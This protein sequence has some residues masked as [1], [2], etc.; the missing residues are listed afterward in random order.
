MIFFE[1]F[2]TKQMMDEKNK[3][4]ALGLLLSLFLGLLYFGAF[5][6]STS[7]AIMLTCFLALIVAYILLKKDTTSSLQRHERM[8]AIALFLF[9]GS[10]LCSFIIGEGYKLESIRNPGMPSFLDLDLASKYLIGAIFFVLFFKI[11]FSIRKKIVFYAIVL[12]GV[13]SGL[14]AIYQRYVLGWSRVSGMSGIAEFADESSILCILSMV[15]F[16][17]LSA[18]KEKSLFAFSI[19]LSSFAVFLTGT[20]G[21]TLG[22]F[23]STLAFVCLIW[24]YKRSFLKL[25]IISSVFVF[26]SFTSVALFSGGVK[27]ALRVESAMSDIEYYDQGKTHTSIGLRFEMWKEAIAMFKM[28]PFFGLTTYEISKSLKEIRENSGSTIMRDFS[29]NPRNE[30]IGKKHNQI[31]NAAAK[32]GIVGV[33]VLLFVWFAYFKLFC[34]YLKAKQPQIFALALSALLVEF[35][36]LFPNSFTGDV[37]ESN[38]SV[39]L[40][41]LSVCLFYKLIKQEKENAL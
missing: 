23:L 27:D 9:F 5:W 21:A 30:A 14:I 19:F 39:P 2:R 10:A 25:A 18:R 40:I 33:F 22:M 36:Y 38:V 20:R 16:V 29:E 31:L 17:F 37:W 24:F 8:F 3:H 26:L 15:I 32:R 7:F 1:N 6:R 41:I 12:G 35:Y 13:A 4:D 34:R 28:A 11:N